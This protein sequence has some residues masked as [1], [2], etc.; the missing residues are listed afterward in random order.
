MGLSIRASAATRREQPYHPSRVRLTSLCLTT[1]HLLDRSH[2]N[3]QCLLNGKHVHREPTISPISVDD[4]DLLTELC[5]FIANCV[6]HFS[7][8]EALSF[9]D[10]EMC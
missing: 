8:G 5:I 4:F 10:L 7:H 2:Q 1:T 6:A 9:C 3:T